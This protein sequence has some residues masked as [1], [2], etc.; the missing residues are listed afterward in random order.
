[1]RRK[2][3]LP[4]DVDIK[5]REREDLERGTPPQ[6]KGRVQKNSGEK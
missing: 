4:P 2:G 5:R 1:V 6:E 3:D